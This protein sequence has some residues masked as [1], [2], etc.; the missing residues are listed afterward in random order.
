MWLLKSLFGGKGRPAPPSSSSRAEAKARPAKAGARRGRVV[1]DLKTFSS[2][3]VGES[4]Q[5]AGHGG[6]R[7][8]TGQ[9]GL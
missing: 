1:T 5:D 8:L 7:L 2:D 9:P 3:A 6:G 4:N